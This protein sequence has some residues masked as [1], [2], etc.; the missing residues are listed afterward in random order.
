MII[1]QSS[2]FNVHRVWFIGLYILYKLRQSKY[3]IQILNRSVFKFTLSAWNTWNISSQANFAFNKHKL[4]P[5][6]PWKQ[7]CFPDQA[8]FPGH[9]RFFVRKCQL[10]VTN[11]IGRRGSWLV[12]KLANAHF[13]HKHE[14]NYI[15]RTYPG[16]LLS[17]VFLGRDCNSLIM[18]SMIGTRSISF[19]SA[20]FLPL[21]RW[22]SLDSIWAE[23]KTLL[24]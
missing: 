12:S 2:L 11:C 10:R 22:K 6:R 17:S 9:Y 20:S 21:R 5:K 1:V 18:A 23:K 15:Y 16:R 19:S 24:S 13:Y 3:I 4:P 8:E 7:Y 14:I